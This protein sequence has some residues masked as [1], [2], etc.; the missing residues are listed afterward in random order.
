[1]RYSFFPTQSFFQDVMGE[2]RRKKRWEL[3]LLVIIVYLSCAQ[4]DIFHYYKLKKFLTAVAFARALGRRPTILPVPI[5]I[6]IPIHQNEVIKVP[7]QTGKAIVALAG[8]GHQKQSIGHVISGSNI[9]SSLGKGFTGSSSFG[10]ALPGVNRVNDNII[11]LS[12]LSGLNSQNVI[13]VSPFG[14]GSNGQG[15]TVLGGQSLGNV[16][17]GAGLQ[18]INGGVQ[19]S[20]LPM[21]L[22][23]SFSVD[24]RRSYP[25]PANIYLDKRRRRRNRHGG[26][27]MRSYD[28]YPGSNSHY[29]GSRSKRNRYRY[30]PQSYKQEW[31]SNVE[32]LPPKKEI[33]KPITV[34][35]KFGSSR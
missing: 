30:K 26:R 9:L 27:R 12:S 33:E 16:L 4:A 22:Q 13:A 28:Y 35:E 5:P 18:D 24:S 23:G 3:T 6:P 7:S 10:Y 21:D 20:G 14:S 29:Y 34:G 19:I 1:M 15:I 17:Q 25:I 32:V 31:P 8:G 2:M 11:N